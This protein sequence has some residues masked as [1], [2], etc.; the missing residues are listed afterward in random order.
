VHAGSRLAFGITTN[1]FIFGIIDVSGINSA[2]PSQG[3]HDNPF[4]NRLLAVAWFGLDS[5][6]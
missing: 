4:K 2:G 5:V 6:A 1:L 3:K